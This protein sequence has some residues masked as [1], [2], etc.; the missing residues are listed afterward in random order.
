MVTVSEFK[1]MLP[2]LKEKGYILYNLND[3]I[4]PDPDKADGFVNRLVPGDDV[5]IEIMISH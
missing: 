5:L 3:Y 1:K 2:S 4:E